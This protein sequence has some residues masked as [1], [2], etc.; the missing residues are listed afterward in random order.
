MPLQNSA[1]D[2]SVAAAMLG[3]PMAATMPIIAPAV[4]IVVFV[5]VAVW[6]FGHE[7]F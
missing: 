3:R 1:N 4:L 2:V 6:R 7:E 5:A